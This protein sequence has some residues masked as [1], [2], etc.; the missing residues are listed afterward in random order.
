MLDIIAWTCYRHEKDGVNAYLPASD[1]EPA[2]LSY[3]GAV[4]IDLAMRQSSEVK[5]PAEILTY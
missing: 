2:S 4:G 1:I 3:S 5:Q